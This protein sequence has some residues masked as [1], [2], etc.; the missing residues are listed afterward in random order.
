VRGV[1]CVA[2]PDLIDRPQV[3]VG[4]QG[5]GRGGVAK[6]LLDRLHR[7]AGADEHRGV[8]VPEGVEGDVGAD[9]DPGGAL[10]EQL[11]AAVAANRPAGLGGGAA[12]AIAAFLALLG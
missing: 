9:A 12:G 2:G 7:A 8:V 10:A 5:L 4:V 6:R 3:R 11:D 1:D